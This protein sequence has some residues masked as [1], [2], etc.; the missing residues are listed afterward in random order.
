M[1]ETTI[2]ICAPF[3]R[4]IWRYDVGMSKSL[5]VRQQRFC[6][7]VS[8]GENQTDAWIK[9]GYKTTRSAARRNASEAMTKPD[10]RERIG[11]LQAENRK[12]AHKTK[13]DKLRYL[14]GIMSNRRERS[15]DRIR[16]IR[17]HNEMTGD[18][19]P[20][21]VVVDS[22]PDILASLQERAKGMS[23]ALALQ[24][25]T[26]KSARLASID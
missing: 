13:S 6:E 3:R 4:Q 2:A 8:A 26:M 19:E 24:I 9:A 20:T 7:F 1:S 21:K 23:S 25:E 5:N 14:E 17:V 10:I 11:E 15:S 12:L 16:S 18:N 22:G